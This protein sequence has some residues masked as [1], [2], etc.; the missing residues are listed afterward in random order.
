MSV[1]LACLPD[2]SGDGGGIRR[3][4]SGL[5]LVRRR[6]GGTRTA[7]QLVKPPGVHLA[8]QKIGFNKDTA[9][10]PHIGLDAGDGVLLKGTARGR[11]YCRD[12]RRKD[13]LPY[14]GRGG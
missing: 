6:R 9:E 5:I 2:G 13:A 14:H 10:K 3:G 12:P 1:P 8:A 7:E 11:N 4:V